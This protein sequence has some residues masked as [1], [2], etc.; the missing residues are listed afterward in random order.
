MYGILR[1]ARVLIV[2]A[3]NQRPPRGSITRRTLPAPAYEPGNSERQV[4]GSVATGEESAW[5]ATLAV[6][7]R[8]DQSILLSVE[9]QGPVPT[10][11]PLVEDVALVIPLD[12][13]DAVLTLLH[14]IVAQARRDGVLPRRSYS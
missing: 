13:A 8:G 5:F 1:A 7:M 10:G 11:A 3:D 9:R 6:A 14:G 12:E 4:N 2:I